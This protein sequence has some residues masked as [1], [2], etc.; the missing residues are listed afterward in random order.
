MES[1][2]K[3]EDLFAEDCLLLNV[4]ILRAILLDLDALQMT[5]LL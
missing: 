5:G 2:K 4:E 1:G 3:E